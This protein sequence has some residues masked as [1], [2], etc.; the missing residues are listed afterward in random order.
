MERA[1]AETGRQL[2]P[3]DLL[4][5]NAGHEGQIGVMW[6]LDPETWWR[7][8]D[9][10]LRGPYLCARAVVPGMIARG[11]GRIVTTASST[12]PKPFPGLSAYAT[13]KT[14]V[15]R[16]CE[17]LAAEVAEHGISVF[18]IHPGGIKTALTASQ[19]TS[20]AAR[21]W[22][23]QIYELVAQGWPGQPPEPA[24]ELVV[25]LASGQ[26]DALS[27]CFIRVDD[28]VTEMAARAQEIRQD[29]LYTLRLRT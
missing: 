24:A 27:G 10:N 2:G 4:V 13:S 16:L 7:C 21:K 23:P 1:V 18:A 26:A 6:E 8:M 17:T 20:D 11:R 12:G 15:I 3:V 29:E 9:V 22:F 25:F 28:D 19:F 5:S 14:A